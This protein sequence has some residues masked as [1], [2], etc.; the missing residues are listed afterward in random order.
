MMWGNGKFSAWR[1]LAENRG[2][3][4]LFADCGLID[5]AGSG[6]VRLT[7]GV[8]AFVGAAMLDPRIGRW[9]EGY[10]FPQGDP[11]LQSLGVLIM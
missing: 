9:K 11:V 8:A 3:G 10:E 5:F 6:V 7:G 2:D 1:S 4:R